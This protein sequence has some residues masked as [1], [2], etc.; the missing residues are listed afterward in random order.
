[1]T[2]GKKILDRAVHV[3]TLY[4]VLKWDVHVYMCVVDYLFFGLE[5]SKQV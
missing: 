2:K 1:M 5:F 4:L 3:G